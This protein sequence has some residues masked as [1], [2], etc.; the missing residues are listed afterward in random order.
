[1]Q[2]YALLL[3]LFVLAG[4]VGY[5]VI[6]RVTPALYSPLMSVT[7]AI[8]GIVVVGAITAA[9]TAEI[10]VSTWLGF[11]AVILASIN[12]FGG[13]AITQRML[14]MFQTKKQDKKGDKK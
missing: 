3:T 4:F 9:A 8:S 7:N 5:Y 6:L 13:F 1:M 12:V 11:G 2:D 10:T 14:N